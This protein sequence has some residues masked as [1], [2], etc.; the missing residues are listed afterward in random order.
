VVYSLLIAC[1]AGLV[2]ALF[3]ILWYIHSS[4]AIMGANSQYKDSV[5][6]LLFG[7][8]GILRELYSAIEGAPLDPAVSIEINTLSNVLFHG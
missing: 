3:A 5:F 6:S 8:P 2:L 1:L 4:E 7:H